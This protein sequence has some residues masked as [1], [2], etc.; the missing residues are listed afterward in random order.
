MVPSPYGPWRP[1]VLNEAQ[2]DV[3]TFIA[4]HTVQGFQ[5]LAGQ[6]VQVG[7]G[8]AY[9]LIRSEL[10]NTATSG[11]AT[12]LSASYQVWIERAAALNFM[13]D[14][15][16]SWLIGGGYTRIHP[17]H[18]RSD[19]GGHLHLAIVLRQSSQVA[20]RN[21]WCFIQGL[22]SVVHGHRRAGCV[23]PGFG[24][25]QQTGLPNATQERRRRPRPCF[26]MRRM[27]SLTSAQRAAY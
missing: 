8:A 14:V 25:W 19:G 15:P 11:D 12:A 16:E 3:L 22:R 5:A 20:Q 17:R 13:I 21:W 27:K 7:S 2:V 6:F 9:S 1:G 18:D 26:A 23:W 10:A 24:I 4:A